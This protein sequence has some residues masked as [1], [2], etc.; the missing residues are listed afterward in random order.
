VIYPPARPGG[1][2][3][4]A[5]PKKLPKGLKVA[6]AA[7]ICRNAHVVDVDVARCAVDDAAERRI[8]GDEAVIDGQVL[9]V[10][11]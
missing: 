4:R 2:P 11:G 7:G 5:A 8:A 1:H 9:P 6:D 10:R 3:E